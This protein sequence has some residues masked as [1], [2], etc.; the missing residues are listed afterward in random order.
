MSPTP[1]PWAKHKTVAALVKKE[2]SGYRPGRPLPKRKRMCEE[3]RR[4]ARRESYRRQKR[5]QRH[6]V[7]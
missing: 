6:A 7:G 4:A 2:C 3:C 1:K 5:R